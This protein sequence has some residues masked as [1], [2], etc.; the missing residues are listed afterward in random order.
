MATYQVF[1]S[2]SAARSAHALTRIETIEPVP[3]TPTPNRQTRRATPR[4]ELVDAALA[5]FAT[6]GVATTSVDHIVEAADVAKGTFYLYFRTK[7]DAVNAVAE[8]I[9]TQVADPDSQDSP[10]ARAPLSISS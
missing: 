5:V 6:R 10:A 4:T 2:R 3:A 7:D 9:V 1:Q 8:R